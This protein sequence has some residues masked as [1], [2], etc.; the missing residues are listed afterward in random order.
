MV[1]K[2]KIKFLATVIFL[3]LLIVSSIYMTTLPTVHA[4]AITV[5]NRQKATDILDNAVGLNMAAYSSTLV[6]ESANNTSVLTAISKLPQDDLIF[7]LT[8]VQSNLTARCLFING[9]L[10]LLYL[11]NLVG[12]PALNVPTTNNVADAQGFLQ[13]YQTYSVNQIYT[14]LSATLTNVSPNVNMT[15]ES[16]KC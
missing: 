11:S 7:T 1:K 6:S 13:R 2:F 10:N 9:T 5:T 16:R 12:T 14:L 15:K 4:Q 8:T 3:A